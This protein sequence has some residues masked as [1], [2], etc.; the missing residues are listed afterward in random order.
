MKITI[1]RAA[2]T[3]E[4]HEDMLISE[5]L[6]CCADFGLNLDEY[7]IIA[8]KYISYPYIPYF[9]YTPPPTID[10]WIVTCSL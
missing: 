3:I 8:T 2:K 4:L 7:K 5:V 10:P 1:D 6:A 9:P